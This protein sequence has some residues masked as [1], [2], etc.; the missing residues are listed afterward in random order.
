[1]EVLYMASMQKIKSRGINYYSIVES[2]R[3]NGKPTPVRIAYLGNIENI[4]N[5][6]NNYKKG[7]RD[8]NLKSYSHGAVYALW[9]IAKKH[10][11]ISYLNNSFPEQARN[12]LS[13]GETLLLASIY[14]AI[15]P[16]SKN[17]FCEKISETSLPSIVKFDPEKTTS[18]HFW[19][20]MNGIDEKML[21]SAE[22]RI[23]SH[24]LNH[25]NINPGKLAL[26]YTNYFTYIDSN[27]K[28]STLTKRG[29]NKQKR[30]DLRQFSLGLVTTREFAIPLCSYVYEGNITDVTAFPRYLDLFR[31]RIANYTDATDITLIYDNGSVSKKNLAGLKNKSPEFH[32]ICAFSI[33]SCKELLDISVND[34]TIVN[35]YDD[36]NVL[37]YRTT[38][39][40]WGDK[41]ECVLIFSE[42]LYTGQYNGLLNSIKKKQQQLQKLKEQLRNP[43]SRISKKG[44]DIDARVRKIIKG[45]FGEKIFNIQKNGVRV[46]KDIDVFVSLDIA[47]ELC[48]KHYV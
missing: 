28:R 39:N 16:C 11:I 46:I 26:D 5:M 27:N 38:R 12:G 21:Y 31:K 30:N 23:A 37:C 36:K 34:Y 9:N 47:E 15:Y 32:Y 4:L 2:R 14:R 1:V 35:I 17:E 33:N 3:I 6:F 40:I 10:N 43:N 7:S 19:S 18:Q 8:T 29:H 24:I 48:H 45:D 44:S 20:Q 22:D 41:K 25:Y 13:R 42:D